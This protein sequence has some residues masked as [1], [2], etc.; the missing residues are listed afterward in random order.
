MNTK[1]I[2]IFASGGGSNAIKLLN[3]FEK[4][5]EFQITLLLTNNENAG[6]LEKT[7]D[8]VDQIIINNEGANDGEFLTDIMQENAIDYIVLAGY[9]R[10]VPTELINAY[11]SKII[12]IHPALLP[13]Y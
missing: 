1:H 5:K 2:A 8:R 6:V 10:K 11:P 7:R 4:S 12:N 13:K 3:H 9:L